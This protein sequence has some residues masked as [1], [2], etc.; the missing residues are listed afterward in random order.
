MTL[1][2]GFDDYLSPVKQLAQQAPMSISII[3]THAFFVDNALTRLKDMGVANIWSSDSVLHSTNAF[4]I[5]DTLARQL[6]KI[7]I[8][9]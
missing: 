6:K 8:T 2:L 9:D 5:I 3:V 1:I 7:N 4:S